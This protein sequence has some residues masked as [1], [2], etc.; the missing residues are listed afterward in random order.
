MR[1]AQP[2][3]LSP[4]RISLLALALLAAASLMPATVGAPL[5]PELVTGSGAAN[6]ITVYGHGFALEGGAADWTEVCARCHMR[7]GITSPGFT[8]YDADEGPVLLAPGLYELREYSGL[9]TFSVE[10][11]HA[12]FVQLFGGGKIDEIV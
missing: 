9:F 10:G 2:R 8:V 12:F 6:T 7:L 4:A 1:A 3:P 11:R 5:V